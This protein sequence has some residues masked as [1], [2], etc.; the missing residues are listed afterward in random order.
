MT[1][2]AHHSVGFKTTA[3][4]TAHCLT[5]CVI[6]EVTGLA[7]GVSL[8]WAAWQ[9]ITLAVALAFITGMG[10]A[11]IGVMRRHK[12][13]FVSAFRGLWLGEFIS[14][15]V[16]EIAMNWVDWALGGTSAHSVASPIFWTA[17]AFAIPAGYIA[18]FPVN[19]VLLRR[20]LKHCH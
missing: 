13:G 19:Y 14:I 7:I 8:G 6:G 12:S 3:Y 17:L 15:S 20:H 5:G 16:M 11:T 2:Q 1:D 18:A 4:A 9:T 10:L